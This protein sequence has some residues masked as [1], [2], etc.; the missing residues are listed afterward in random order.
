MAEFT[1]KLDPDTRDL[2]FDNSGIMATVEDDDAYTQNVRLALDAW[3]GEFIL[4]ETHGTDYSRILAQDDSVA[5]SE[6]EE[7]IRD[8]ILQE[9][10]V[11]LVNTISAVMAPGRVLTIGFTGE[12]QSGEAISLEELRQNG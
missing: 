7:V 6:A 8:G 12:L 4:D 2:V 11:S 5:D 9:P 10:Q 1:M 3:L